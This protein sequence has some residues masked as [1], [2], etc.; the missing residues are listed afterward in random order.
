MCL[1]PLIYQV[2]HKCRCVVY[3]SRSRRHNYVMAKQVVAVH[4]SLVART[5]ADGE[6]KPDRGQYVD[7]DPPPRYRPRAVVA[8]P[9]A[10][11]HA[12]SVKLL[13]LC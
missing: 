5:T 3:R 11:T 4:E 10:T 9:L 1:T 12:T 7:A 6:P 8:L 13:W 2:L